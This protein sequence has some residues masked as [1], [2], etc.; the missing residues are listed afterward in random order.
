MIE[1]INYSDLKNGD[2][3]D[4]LLVD[5]RELEEVEEGMIDDSVHWPLSSFED[6]K[7][8][9]EDSDQSLVFYCRSGKRSM[10]AAKLAEQW[11]QN[12]IYSLVGGYNAYLNQE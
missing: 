6:F 1:E 11:T 9:I 3:E 10:V 5:V 7:S 12:D 2:I 4:F 8:E